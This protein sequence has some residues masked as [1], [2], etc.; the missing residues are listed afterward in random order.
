[1]TSKPST[2]RVFLT[3]GNPEG[4][5]IAELSN[6]T[7]KAVSAPRTELK[8]LLSREELD[9]PGVYIL[10]GTDPDSGE[11]TVYIGEA[12]AVSQRIKVHINRD[13]WN[14]ATVFTCKDEN[15]TKAH[16]KYLEGRL[17]QRANEVHRAKLI[18]SVSSGTKLPEPDTADM[19]VFLE[20]MYQL[21]PILGIN[22]F[23]TS[24]ERITGESDLYCKIKGLVARGKRTSSGFIVFKGSQAVLSHRP[25]ATTMKKKREQL[26]KSGV[27]VRR[28]KHLVFKKDAEFGS[29]STAG[30]V[31]IGGNCNGLTK[32]KNSDGKSLKDLEQF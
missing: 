3:K 31:V 22:H 32:W 6:W 11:D 14:N 5:R 4:L 13:N 15:L 25:S 1:M 27:L 20:N 29:P 8:E 26:I 30:G 2:I 10:T 24:I 7:G 23:R 19:D 16:I 9:K 28:G 18:N 17:I 21:L 12:E